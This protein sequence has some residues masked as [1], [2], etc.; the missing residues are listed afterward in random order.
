M[1]PLIQ[2]KSIV[3]GI[4]QSIACVPMCYDSDGTPCDET[5]YM[6]VVYLPCGMRT[7]EVAK[8]FDDVGAYAFKQIT[9][10]WEVR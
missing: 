5:Q 3:D 4:V 6:G 9:T 7:N 2:S 10:F 8:L 1:A